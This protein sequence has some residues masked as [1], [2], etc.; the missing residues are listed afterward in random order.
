[1]PSVALLDRLASNITFI[2]QIWKITSSDG[3]VAAFA[4]HTRDLVFESVTY[5]AA[6]V[7]PTRFSETLGLEQANHVELFGVLDEVITES[8]IQGGRWKNAKIVSQYVDY[9]SL[10][11][12]SV[13]KIKGQA[14]KFTIQNGTFRVE[15]RSLTDLLQQ[16]IGDLTSP[17]DRNRTLADLVGAGNLGPY[18]F[19]RSVASVVDRRN[20]TID[21]AAQVDD[22]FRYGKLTFTSGANNGRSME[23]KA[24]VGNVIELQLPMMS[25]V[26][27]GNNVTLLAGYD[28]SR[29]AARDKFGAADNFRGEPDLPGIRGL[30]EYPE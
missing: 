12:G 11:D 19:T 8:D 6:P 4:A 29:T 17:I 27:I 30:I 20:F 24:N 5:K 23:I 2:C 10:A 21:G 13:K 14:G 18:T 28:G 3:L 7:E 1:M 26:A 16:E 25:D 22:Y 15:Q 9:L